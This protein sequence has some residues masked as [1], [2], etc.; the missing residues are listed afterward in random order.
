M[1]LSNTQALLIRRLSAWF[2][3]DETPINMFLGGTLYDKRS[4]GLTY[5]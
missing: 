5:R 4:S 1:Q 3:S 2:L